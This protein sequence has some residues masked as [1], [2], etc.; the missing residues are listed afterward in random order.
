MCL[1]LRV[2]EHSKNMD[3]IRDETLT[4]TKVLSKET[5]THCAEESKAITF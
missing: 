2:S 4:C 1:G 5:I 3:P